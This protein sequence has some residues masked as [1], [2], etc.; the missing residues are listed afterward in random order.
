MNSTICC[1]VRSRLRRKQMGTLTE[2]IFSRRLGRE[3]HAGEIVVAPVDYA[4]AHDVTGPLANE[5]FRKLEVPLRAP[6]RVIIVFN[7]ILP[8]NTVADAA[9]HKNV[10]DFASTCGGSHAFQAG[11]RARWIVE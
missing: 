6:E 1:G 8:E 10:P 2:E 7:H 4:M 5:A 11:M 9:L 3:V